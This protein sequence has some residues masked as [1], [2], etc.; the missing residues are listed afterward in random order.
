MAF[1]LLLNITQYGLDLDFPNLNLTRKKKSYR[2]D[3]RSWLEQDWR[4]VLHCSRGG[5]DNQ[6]DNPE[7]SHI[8]FITFIEAGFCVIY[9]LMFYFVISKPKIFHHCKLVCLFHYF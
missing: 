1:R 2:N 5:G 9:Y 4:V 3:E 6:R 8:N 7:R